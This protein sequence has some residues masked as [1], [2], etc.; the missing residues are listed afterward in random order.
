MRQ[1]LKDLP[2]ID[3]GGFFGRRPACRDN[4]DIVAFYV[5]FLPEMFAVSI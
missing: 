1:G 2:A 3:L 4:K 5:F